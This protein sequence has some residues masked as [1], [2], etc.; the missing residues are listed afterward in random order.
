MEFSYNQIRQMDVVSVTDGK[1]LG[2]VCDIVFSFPE[3]R[4]CGFNVTGSKGFKLTRPDFFI[5]LSAVVRIGEDVII[6]DAE[7]V[8]PP[9]DKCRKPLFR[10]PDCHSEEHHQE[11]APKARRNYD[12][13]E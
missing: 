3:G 9:K 12:E 6:T 1:H 13:Y 4:V 11:C 7:C 10:K 2:R 5:P 8:T